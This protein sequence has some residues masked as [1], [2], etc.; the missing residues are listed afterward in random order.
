M[1]KL[2]YKA[3]RTRPNAHWLNM[4]RLVSPWDQTSNVRWRPGSPSLVLNSTAVDFRRAIALGRAGCLEGV[5]NGKRRGSATFGRLNT[6]GCRSGVQNDNPLCSIIP[7]AICSKSS[8]H[9]PAPRRLL[10]QVF[11]YGPSGRRRGAAR[12]APWYLEEPK[13]KRDVR[14]IEAA[15]LSQAPCHADAT[16][17]L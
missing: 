7:Y 12:G 13:D 10:C 6:M 11:W 1:L 2:L 4:R 17:M 8:K 15:V 9:L 14:L 5:T 16:S 3:S